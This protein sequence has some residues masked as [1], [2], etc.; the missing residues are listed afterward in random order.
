M[1]SFRLFAPYFLIST[2]FSYANPNPSNVLQK[3]ESGTMVCYPDDILDFSALCPE[4][5]YPLQ[6]GLN[7]IE[8]LFYAMS[9]TS[10]P[11]DTVYQ[12]QE[13]IVCMTHS[14]GTNVTFSLDGQASDGIL[15]AGASV[16]FSLTLSGTDNGGK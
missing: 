8:V 14:P 1:K 12:A 13:N 11:D 6:D 4:T 16:T 7:V 5:N 15:G 10:V 3:R 2:A 9:S